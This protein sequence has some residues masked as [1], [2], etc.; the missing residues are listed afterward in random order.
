MNVSLTKDLLNET[1][2]NLKVDIFENCLIFEFVSQIFFEILV[3][4]FI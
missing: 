4:N 3:R 2:F 1:Y